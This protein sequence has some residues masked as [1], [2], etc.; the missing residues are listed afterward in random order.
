[1]S[2]ISLERGRCCHLVFGSMHVVPVGVKQHFVPVQYFFRY[3]FSTSHS[4]IY[5]YI[6]FLKL[7]CHYFARW[8]TGRWGELW[9]Q[10]R[11]MSLFM[12]AVR[13]QGA[14]VSRA[15]PGKLI[16]CWNEDTSSSALRRFS[17]H[18]FPKELWVL[19]NSN[20]YQNCIFMLYLSSFA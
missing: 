20:S 10:G 7:S 17:R 16:A 8:S 4:L 14:S 11:A 15:G 19:A 6:Y 12:C 1:M 13:E 5:I 9:L 18:A 3:T 2:K